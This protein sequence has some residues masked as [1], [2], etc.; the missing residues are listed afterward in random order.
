MGIQ[1]GRLRDRRAVAAAGCPPT[2]PENLREMSA[3]AVTVNP[4]HLTETPTA[5]QWDRRTD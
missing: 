3:A 5:T 4:V 2:A 1:R